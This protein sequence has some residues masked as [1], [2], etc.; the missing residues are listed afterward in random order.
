MYQSDVLNSLSLQEEAAPSVKK[1][2]LIHKTKV[3][4]PQLNL[5]AGKSAQEVLQ[6]WKIFERHC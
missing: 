3:P 4:E 1:L 5:Q 2:R 6:V